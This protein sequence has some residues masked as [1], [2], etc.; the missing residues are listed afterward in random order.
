M[1][2]YKTTNRPL[3]QKCTY[4]LEIDPNLYENLVSDKKWAFHISW[5]N[6]TEYSVNTVR[7]TSFL[8]AEEN[9][10]NL[11]Y[12]NSGCIKDIEIKK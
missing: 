4:R 3:E 11:T 9:D 6:K 1:K 2:S 7:T 10:D 8:F 5:G 12:F